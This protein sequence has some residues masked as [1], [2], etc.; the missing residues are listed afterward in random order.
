MTRY[1]FRPFRNGDPPNL[2]DLWNRG[3]PDRGVARPLAAH[4]FDALVMGKLP[5]DRDGLIVAERD[6]RPVGFAHAGFGPAEP[7]GPSHRLD[8]ELGTLAML[9]VDPLLA[10]DAELAAGLVVEAERYLQAPRG[11]RLLRGRPGAA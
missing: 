2:V 9:V 6:G 1:R 7:A 3:L 10:A 4:E 11:E 8:R 5:F